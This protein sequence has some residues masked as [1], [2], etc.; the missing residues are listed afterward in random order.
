MKTF[1]AHITLLSVIIGLVTITAAYCGWWFVEGTAGGLLCGG[2][3]GLLVAVTV[4][5]F[6]FASFHQNLAY[7][8]ENTGKAIQGDLTGKIEDKDYGWGEF[9]L[10]INNV[11][12]I[13]KGVHKW[14][15]LVKD[16]SVTLDQAA[17]Q[18]NIGTEQVSSGS[19][20]Q[21][22][23]VTNLLQAIERLTGQAEDSARQASE[24]AIVAN[25]TVEITE[26]G[27]AAVQ[28]ALKGMNLL[29]EKFEQLNNSSN[30]IGQFLEVIQ[31]IAA[32]TNLLA[33]NA[34]IEAARAGEHG[35]G[36]A[37]VAEEVRSLAEDSGQATKEVSQIVNEISAAVADTVHAVKTSLDK[38]REAGEIFSDISNTM[39][40]TNIMVEKIAQSARE[41]ADST[42][43]MLSG[44]QAIA[45][46]AEEAAASSQQTA[47]IA[48]ELTGTANKLKEVA[49]IWK[50]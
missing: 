20:D 43:G 23:Q 41:Q 31:S 9:N 18:I 26:R 42:A 39:R 30:R 16:T 28:E 2:L 15:A 38:S 22:E 44:A 11:R 17:K 49:A 34:A 32:Q 37:V 25:K 48:Q 45:A 1:R 40:D 6:L 19:Q 14:F 10:L 13:L 46:V 47:A 3:A 21:A 24:T 33:L 12:K 5:N 29:E 27:S 35:R 50:F 36:F 4:C 8:L 7:V